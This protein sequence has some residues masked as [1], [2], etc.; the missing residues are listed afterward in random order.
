MEQTRLQ[1]E[2]QSKTDDAARISA[3]KRAQAL[4]GAIAASDDK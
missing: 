2:N 3:E 4:N 1:A